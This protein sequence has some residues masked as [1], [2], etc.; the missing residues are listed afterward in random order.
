MARRFASLT[1]GAD[2]AGSILARVDRIAVEQ[3]RARLAVRHHVAPSERAGSVVDVARGVVCLHATDPASVYL[4]AWARTGEAAIADVDRALYEDRLLVRMLAMRRTMFVVPVEDAPVL[5]AAASLAIARTERRRNEQLVALL[6]VD[7]AAA[8]LE[9]A[10][11]AT[12]A[13]LERRSEATAQELSA[14]VPALRQKVRV[15]VGKRYEGDIG[16]SSRV[17]L[18]LALE[19]KIVRGRPRGTWISSQYRWASTAR[20]LGGA[21]PELATAEAQATV[22]RRWLSRFGPGTETDIRWWTG[23]TARDVRAA[24]ATVGAVEVD[25]GGTA[26]LV[27][28]DDLEPTQAPEPWVAL[29]PALDATTMGWKERDW[30]LGEHKDALFDTNGNAGPTI[31]ADGRIVGGWATRADGEVVTKLLED[32]GREASLAV[33]AEAARLTAWLQ[34]ARVVPRFPTPLHRELVG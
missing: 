27:L 30:Y 26:G 34:A 17:L 16:M 31:W 22:V 29:L 3:R 23:W 11:A 12:V 9:E 19:G 13:A 14:E 8:W 6:G 1:D 33:D 2:R 24:L 32:V 7:D 25:L 18:L 15:N 4:S 20:W 21:L 28:P 5:H 10:E